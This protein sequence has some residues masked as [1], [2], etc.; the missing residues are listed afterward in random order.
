MNKT[1]IMQAYPI[2]G[3]V[4][5]LVFNTLFI[6]LALAI[7]IPV[8]ILVDIFSGQKAKHPLNPDR[9]PVAGF[10]HFHYFTNGHELFEDMKQSISHARH[11]IH[12]SFFIFT[13]DEIGNEWLQLLKKKAGEGVEVRLLVDSL[14]GLG[15]RKKRAEL[16]KAGVN[17]AF[18]GKVTF[19]FTFYYLNRRN[20]R[21]I[22]VID[23]EIGYFG[24]FNVS[25]DYIGR[26]PERGAWH[27]NHIKLLGESV[28]E[29]QRQ[30]LEDWKTATKSDLMNNETYFPTV[31][32][33]PSQLTLI[34]TDGKQIEDYFVEKLSSAKVSI[35]IG[36]PYFVPSKKLMDAL[37]DRLS[38]GI[39]LTIL[40]PKKKDHILVQPASFL[41]LKPLVQ[42]GARLF[43]FYQG[44]YHSKI[45]VV[46]RKLCYIGT[47]NFDQRSLFW[48]D[49]LSGFTDDPVLIRH[50]LQKLEKE[51]EN[52]SMPVTLD[53]IENRSPLD[54]LKSLCCG[55]FSFFL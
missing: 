27:D 30:F 45:F 12:L 39:K 43:H 7:L 26:R 40:L 14:T 19:P 48:N 49:E 21:K 53:Q 51:I 46:D 44:F 2:G 29:L 50:A 34:A 3:H 38:C 28:H 4:M 47:A 23:G 25:R 55:W 18:S 42:K 32:K 16:A 15:L 20:H 11:H 35:V 10:N 1:I 13:A 8:A 31:E 52:L 36:S 33:G 5:H 17:L 6:I 9:K 37:M 54:K 41:Y 24:G 22:M